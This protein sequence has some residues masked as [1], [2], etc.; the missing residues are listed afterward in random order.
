MGYKT[1]TFDCINCGVSKTTRTT[2]KT[3]ALKYCS[4]KCQMEYQGKLKVEQWLLTGTLNGEFASTH[5]IRKHILNE[6]N[7]LC[8]ICKI[9]PQWMEKPIT[10]VLD[11]IDGN[12]TNNNRKNLRLICPNCDSQS[13]TFK[14]RNKGKGRHYRRKRYA[15]GKSY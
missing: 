8:E 5:F 6:Q 1:V 11:H 12:S 14:A 10:F 13:P 4:N 15:E 7:N 2:Q 3:P 9:P